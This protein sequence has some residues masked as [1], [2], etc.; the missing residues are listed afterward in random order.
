MIN[1]ILDL[2]QT[3]LRSI[4]SKSISFSARVESSYISNKANIWRRCVV[5]HSSVDDYS[6][7][8]P[9]TRLIH[10]HVGKFCSIAGD[11]QI[12]MGKHSLCF[13]STSPIFTSK[14]NGTGIKWTDENIIEE[15]NDIVIGNDVWIGSSAKIMGGIT[16]GDGA[17]IGAGAIV[18]K[19]VPPYA[20]VVGVPAEIKKYRF[21]SDLISRLNEIKWWSLEDE[22]IRKKIHLFQHEMTLADIDK[23]LIS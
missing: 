5:S 1:R 20:V 9:S 14:K 3:K 4:F 16:I 10:A 12:G 11:C 19:N 15:Y 6:Y 23:L 17:V 21:S 8:G 13:M 2:L 7:I 18:T 22:I